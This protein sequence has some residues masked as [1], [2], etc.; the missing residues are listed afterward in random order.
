[1][2]IREIT[3]NLTNV[4][5]IELYDIPEDT[6]GTRNTVKILPLL[7]VFSVNQKLNVLTVQPILM[8]CAMDNSDI[9][10]TYSHAC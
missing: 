9:L 7:S 10:Y 1:M 6:D 5:C 3:I 8:Y 4:Y 2:K